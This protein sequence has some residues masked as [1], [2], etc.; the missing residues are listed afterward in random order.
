MCFF[1][2]VTSITGVYMHPAACPISIA[3]NFIQENVLFRFTSYHAYPYYFVEKK[4]SKNYRSELGV[5]EIVVLICGVIAA[6]IAL[7][8]FIRSYIKE[9][10]KKEQMLLE[11]KLA[12][13][14]N[15]KLSINF[16]KICHKLSTKN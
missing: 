4:P 15:K 9:Q 6:L 8:R 1:Y 10:I 2:F 13:F 7:V 3:N 12:K 11:I 5:T 14:L 16:K